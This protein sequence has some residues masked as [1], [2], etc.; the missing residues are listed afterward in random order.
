MVDPQGAWYVL[1]VTYQRELPTREALTRLGIETFVP[2]RI[3]RRRDRRGRFFTVREAALHNYNFVR[4]TKR[5]IG[6]LKNF[7]LPMLPH[8]MHVG[9]GLKRPMIVP[10]AQMRHFM[11]VAGSLQPQV[12][13][14][15]PSELDLAKGDR[16]RI[17]G[18]LF[19]GVEGILLRIRQARERRVIVSIEGV[20]AVA[21][22]SVP[23]SQIEKIP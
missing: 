16:V 14:L 19:A 3:V 15:S 22:T 17:T 23:A 10:E 13:Y 4:T 9:E 7:P 20:A 18:G 6:E 12:L 21:T 8:V 2:E 1:R 11:A 5:G